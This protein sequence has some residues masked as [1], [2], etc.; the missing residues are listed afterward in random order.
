MFITSLIK[1]KQVTFKRQCLRT[2]SHK[3]AL[4][5]VMNT[6]ISLKCLQYPNISILNKKRMPLSLN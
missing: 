4:G 2:K 1:K 5:S 3:R 6:N